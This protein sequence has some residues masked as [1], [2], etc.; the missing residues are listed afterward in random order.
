MPTEL[1]VYTPWQLAVFHITVFSF[2]VWS[3][4]LHFPICVNSYDDTEL[5]LLRIELFADWLLQFVVFASSLYRVLS[6]SP[7]TEIH[8]LIKILNLLV[9]LYYNC[10][11]ERVIIRMTLYS[12]QLTLIT[13]K[14]SDTLVIKKTCGTQVQALNQVLNQVP[15]IKTKSFFIVFQQL[16]NLQCQ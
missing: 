11:Y 3:L 16:N 14:C 5:A 4:S 15:W 10:F 8:C 7:I 12:S 9:A 13:S 2:D 6:F 1:G